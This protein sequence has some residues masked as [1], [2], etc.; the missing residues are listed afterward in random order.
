MTKDTDWYI[1]EQFDDKGFEVSFG[2]EALNETHVITDTK[3]SFGNYGKVNTKADIT[4]VGD[5]VLD[6]KYYTG[7]GLGTVD[8]VLEQLPKHIKDKAHE[9]VND[10]SLDGYTIYDCIKDVHKVHGDTVVVSAGGNDL[11]AKLPM[12]KVSKDINVVMNIMNN[13]LNKLSLA[14]ETLLHECKKQGR[15]FLLLTTYDGNLAFNPQR[16]AGVDEIAKSILSMWNE[17]LYRLA[18]DQQRRNNGQN[19]DVLELRNFMAT[20]C[21][22]NEIEPNKRGAKRIAKNINKYLF[23]NGV[24]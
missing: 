4:F 2:N 7:T 16:F 5:S 1:D 20:T 22:Y 12:L 3:L 19:F 24:W 10:I 21:F 15:N 17:R 14:Y 13:E 18:N 11:L 8:Y 23:D 6:C 9:R